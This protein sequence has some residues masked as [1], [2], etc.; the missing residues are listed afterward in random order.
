MKKY[1]LL[2]NTILKDR[3]VSILSD[4]TV[5]DFVNFGDKDLKSEYVLSLISSLTSR[6][7][8]ERESIKYILIAVSEKSLTQSRI[9]RSIGLG[10]KNA[11]NVPLRFISEE[12]LKIIFETIK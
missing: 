4:H 2:L 12:E 11:L 1:T 5:V 10:L 6:S 7:M 8:V 3:N 9:I